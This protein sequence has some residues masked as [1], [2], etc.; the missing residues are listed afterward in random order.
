MK[1]EC[2]I[3]IK[4]T[5]LRHLNNQD[6]FSHTRK[7]QRKCKEVVLKQNWANQESKNN[8]KLFILNKHI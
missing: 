8:I 6:P 7:M 2:D 5:T 1:K 4:D 3:Q